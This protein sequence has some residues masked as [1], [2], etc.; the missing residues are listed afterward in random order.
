MLSEE[1]K[2]EGHRA[3]D[4][5]E[6]I[7]TTDTKYATAG[8]TDEQVDYVLGLV[9]E[10]DTK[11]PT[12]EQIAT[13][14]LVK[15]AGIIEWL[16]ARKGGRALNPVVPEGRYA[17]RT[18]DIGG[19]HANEVNFY[20]VSLV[21]KPG[22]KWDGWTFVE[23][24]V[25]EETYP[26]KGRA[27]FDIL[28]VIARDLEGALALYGVE[29]EKC[30]LCGRNLTNDVSR[31]RGTGRSAQARP[32]SDP[33]DCRD[34]RLRARAVGAD[35]LVTKNILRRIKEIGQPER[36]VGGLTR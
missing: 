9:A 20:E 28:R 4:S 23:H 8:A 21:M 6:D 15:A 13:W 1:R 2:T 11:A 16:L 22:T 34:P 5:T 35:R 24:I 14:T 25:S 7:M 26:V 29:K 12:V 32:G 18:A 3:T 17:L 36:D 30:G 31:Q 10:L 27:K 19:E 33:T